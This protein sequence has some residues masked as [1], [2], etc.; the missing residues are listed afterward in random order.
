[1]S[2][3]L[4]PVGAGVGNEGNVLPRRDSNALTLLGCSA[5]VPSLQLEL[6]PPPDISLSV[7][8]DTKMPFLGFTFC[9]QEFG[10]GW[11]RRLFP[12]KSS[13]TPNAFAQLNPSR[14]STGKPRRNQGCIPW[15]VFLQ[16][17]GA[18][19]RVTAHSRV[20]A[21]WGGCPQARLGAAHQ[22]IPF[23]EPGGGSRSQSSL[24]PWHPCS[25]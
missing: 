11:E 12:Y 17:A 8:R 16:G 19:T 18:G 10:R 24:W 4:K 15:I 21:Q 1:M 9:F 23:L 2:L 5:P 25:G 7:D 22:E 20:A 6:P 14:E 13:Q 3:I